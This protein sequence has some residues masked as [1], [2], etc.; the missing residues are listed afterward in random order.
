MPSPAESLSH[1]FRRDFTE[2]GEIVEPAKQ[3]LGNLGFFTIS[4]VSWFII[5]FGMIA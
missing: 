1:P 3:E 2:T 4:F 5:I